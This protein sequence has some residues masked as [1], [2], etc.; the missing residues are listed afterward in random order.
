MHCLVGLS[1]CAHLQLSLGCQSK[2]CT[3]TG[4]SGS[5]FN[6]PCR[7]LCPADSSILT[8][9]KSGLLAAQAADNAGWR[10][11]QSRRVSSLA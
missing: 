7:Y 1:M 5:C 8:L 9:Y 2:A 10:C 6:A 11:H 4:S 3:S